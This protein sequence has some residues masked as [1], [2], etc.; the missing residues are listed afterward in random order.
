MVDG[1]GRCGVSEPD[2]VT[3]RS[4]SGLSSRSTPRQRV[5]AAPNPLAN[6][7][8]N[9]RT[10]IQDCENCWVEFHLPTNP[11]VTVSSLEDV[12]KKEL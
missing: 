2:R 6:A 10:Q 8:A 7:G 3:T 9:E 1:Q 5:H 12:T 4:V 11:S